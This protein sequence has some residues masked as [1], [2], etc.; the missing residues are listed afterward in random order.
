MTGIRVLDLQTPLAQG[1]KAAIFGGAGAGKTVLVMELIQA[2]ATGYQ[3]ISVFAGV[4]ERSCE[5]DEKLLEMQL[6]GLLGRVVD[7]LGRPLD[8]KGE[9]TTSGYLP[10]E[11][12]AS[13]IID[14]EPVTRPVET[15]RLR[16]ANAFAPCCRSHALPSCPW[17]VRLPCCVRST[18]MFSPEGTKGGA[19]LQ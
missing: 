19:R 3:G 6:S 2:M 18:P 8:G 1:S 15:G 4:G 13:E 12:P 16:A 7:P 10:A 5:G 9:I 14:R 17:L 11:R